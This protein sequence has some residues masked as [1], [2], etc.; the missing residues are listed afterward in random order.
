MRLMGYGGAGSAKAHWRD[1]STGAMRP[2]WG[3]DPHTR[4]ESVRILGGIGIS[5]PMSLMRPGCP[6]PDQLLAGS[7]FH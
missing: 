1:D 5:G 4:R 2:R 6:G 7:M 3:I